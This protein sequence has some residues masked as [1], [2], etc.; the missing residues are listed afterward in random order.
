MRG[1]CWNAA[2]CRM[3]R[4][5]ERRRV[6]N[7]HNQQPTNNQPQQTN[8]T[9]PTQ[10]TLSGVLTAGMF[11]FISNAKPLD[12]LSATRPHP[13]IFN[14]YFFGSLMGQFAAQLGFLIWMYRWGWGVVGGTES[15]GVGGRRG[16][17]LGCWNGFQVKQGRPDFPAATPFHLHLSSSLHLPPPHPLIHT[18]LPNSFTPPTPLTPPPI[19]AAL[20]T[21]SSEEA[22]ASDSDFKPNLVNSVCYLV[23][24]VI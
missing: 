17:W 4:H 11:F 6:G 8:A 21:M 9:N 14:P 13:S 12:Q 16:V 1:R 7:D 23:E 2:A 10:A 20:A 15:G 5:T 18:P 19:R 22:Q 3:Y 24:Q